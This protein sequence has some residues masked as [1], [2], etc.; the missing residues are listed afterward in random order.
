MVYRSVI[1]FSSENLVI[2]NVISVESFFAMT[3]FASGFFNKFV[4]KDS[5]FEHRSIRN[6]GIILSSSEIGHFVALFFMFMRINIALALVTV[7][8]PSFVYL[9]WQI[10]ECIEGERFCELTWQGVWGIHYVLILLVDMLE[11]VLLL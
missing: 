2:C 3:N 9:L 7:Y 4:S 10:G 6:Y 11:V 5:M 8:F 1:G